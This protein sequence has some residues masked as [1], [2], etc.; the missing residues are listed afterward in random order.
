M[1]Y[2]EHVYKLTRTI[3]GK[4]IKGAAWLERCGPDKHIQLKAKYDFPSQ[5]LELRCTIDADGGNYYRITCIT[6][7]ENI[8][9][10]NEQTGLEALFQRHAQ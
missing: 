5:P 8:K 7:Y 3:E 1:Q 10:K 2:S 9:P 4:S 6:K